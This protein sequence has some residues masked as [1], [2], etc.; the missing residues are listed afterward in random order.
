[1][2]SKPLNIFRHNKN[3][4]A[5][6]SLYG[7]IKIIILTTLRSVFLIGD[8]PGFATYMDSKTAFIYE[9]INAYYNMHA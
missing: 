4:A 2:C 8:A 3:L 5:P 1:M 7:F 6:Q 9:N